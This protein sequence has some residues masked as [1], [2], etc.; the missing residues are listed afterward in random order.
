MLMMS[1]RE[2]EKIFI[3]NDIE[4]AIA[5]IGRHRVKLAIRAPRETLVIPREIKLVRDENVKAAAGPRTPEALSGLIARLQPGS[6]GRG[7]R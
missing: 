1:R 4:I 5:Q 3:G 2:G 6:G 7:S